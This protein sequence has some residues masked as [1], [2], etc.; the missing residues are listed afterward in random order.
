[1]NAFFVLMGMYAAVA[2]LLL[3]S[4]YVY[5]TARDRRNKQNEQQHKLDF[6]SP[7]ETP[8]PKDRERTL[9]AR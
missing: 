3:A 1:M 8:K 7:A 5:K 6:N 9:L 4:G 2:A